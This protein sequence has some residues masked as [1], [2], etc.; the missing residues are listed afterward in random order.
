MKT[1]SAWLMSIMIIIGCT[2]GTTPAPET[3]T[4]RGNL[5]SIKVTKLSGSVMSLDNAKAQALKLLE[6]LDK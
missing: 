5:V 4:V 1:F 3:V 2:P 6:K